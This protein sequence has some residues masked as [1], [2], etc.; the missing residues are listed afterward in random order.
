M[1]PKSMPFEV[2][3]CALI[4]IATGTRAQNLKELREKLE[5]IHPDCIYYHFWGGM[6]HSR[7]EEP[8]FGNDFAAW[9]RHAL[10]E[11]ILA[12]RL[13]VI[14]PTDFTDLEELREELIEVIDERLHELEQVPSARP[15]EEF[16]FIRSQIVVFD[17]S[18]RI[19]APEDLPRLLP[20]LSLGSIFYHFIDARRRSPEGLD[21]FRNWLMGFGDR[22]LDLCQRIAA[23]DPYFTT[24]SEIRQ[25]LTSTFVH[26][27]GRV[28]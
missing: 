8:E 15:G 23:I 16:H 17:T 12:E 13:A 4:A 22:Y 10:H 21:D 26:Y 27:F 7:F 18:R 24:L 28:I 2:K 20:N 11:H 6:L 14:D 25:R 5:T 3:D 9:V 1:E 19:K